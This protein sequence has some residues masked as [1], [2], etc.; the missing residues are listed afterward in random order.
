MLCLAGAF[1]VLGSEPDGDSIRFRPN[2]PGDWAKVPGPTAV[3]RNAS[4]AAQLRLDGVDALETHYTPPAGRTVHQPLALG[5]AAAAELLEWLGFRDVTRNGEAV[6]AVAQDDQPGFILTRGADLYGRCVA[7]V[8][9]GA[10]PVASGEQVMVDVALLRET[11]NHR[12]TAT[13][14]TYPT[15]YTKLYLDLRSE[16]AARAIAARAARAGVFKDD[17]TQS[18]VTVESL[19]T[20]TDAALIL[21]KLFRRLTE[22]LQ[23]NGGDPSL[24]GFADFLAQLDDRLWIVPTGE[25][26]AFDSVVAVDGQTVRLIRPPEE[27]VFEEK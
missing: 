25:K 27:L 24:T 15:F 19:A 4:G 7:L 20:L 3:R 22:F 21:P 23:L 13:G 12:L 5:H 6:T 26:T 17:L 18:G 10:P 16:L 8:G 9:R 14:L 1:H 11:A 2:D